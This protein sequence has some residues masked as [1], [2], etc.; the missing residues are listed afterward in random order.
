MC[1]MKIK[2]ISE[3]VCIR[4]FMESYYHIYDEGE[5]LRET[6]KQNFGN[7]QNVYLFNVTPKGGFHPK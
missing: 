6:Q 3:D 4:D 1:K 2:K 5:E 7:S